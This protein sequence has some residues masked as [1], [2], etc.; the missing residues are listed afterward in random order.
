MDIIDIAAEALKPLSDDGITVRQGWYDEGLHKIHVTLW[1]LSG[2]PNSFSDDD[3]DV[4]FGMIQ[5]NIWSKKDQIS[6]KRRI[7]KLMKSAGF[8]FVEENDEAETDTRIFVNAMR[9]L[10]IREAEETEE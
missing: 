2:R 1:N 4:E 10:L 8:I 9:F 3:E 5:V 7:K 6:L